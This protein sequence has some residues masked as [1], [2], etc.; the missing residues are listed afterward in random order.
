MQ[1]RLGTDEQL[2]ERQNTQNSN[3]I[4]QASIEN[5]TPRTGLKV[6]SEEENSHIASDPINLPSS[7]KNSNVEIAS[8]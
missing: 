2:A 5:K 1:E 8:S 4:W 6:V 3:I 7:R